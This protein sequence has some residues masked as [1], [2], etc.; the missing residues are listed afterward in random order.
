LDNKIEILNEKVDNL[1]RMYQDLKRENESLRNQLIA[2]QGQNETLSNKTRGLEDT[3][4]EKDLE[5]DNI[6]NKINNI[7]S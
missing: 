6:L 2:S 4:D 7:T 3:L 1:V 5:I